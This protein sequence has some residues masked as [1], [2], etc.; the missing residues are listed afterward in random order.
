MSAGRAPAARR[1]VCS[2]AALL[3]L[4]IPSAAAA[5]VD[6]LE[7]LYPRLEAHNCRAC[8]NASGVASE[9]RLHFPEQGAPPSAI[10]RFGESM[11]VLV[12]RDEPGASRLLAKPT[13]RVPHTGGPLIAAGS[14]DERLLAAWTEHLATRSAPQGASEKSPQ[15]PVVGPVRRL[16]HAQ[17]DNSVRDLLG[18]RTRPSRNFPPEDFVNGYTNQASS[19]TITPALAEAYGRAAEKL[20]RHAFRYGDEGGLVPCSPSGP[21]DR[22]CAEAFVRNFGMR[23]YR[24]PLDQ[25]EADELADLLLLWARQEE[26]LP[27][28]RICCGRSDSAVA[29]VPLRHVSGARQPNRAVRDRLE[30]LARALGLPPRFRFGPPRV[31]GRTRH[32]GRN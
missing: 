21:T 22:A 1:V 26:Q 14:E 13:N 3:G 11:H 8:H 16:T 10:R 5:P 28:W 17:Y 20:A 6:F 2:V 29:L 31:S 12:N 18:D 32:F 19:Q 25:G 15:T 23:A 24:R 4:A 9:T 27:D 30:A 7:D